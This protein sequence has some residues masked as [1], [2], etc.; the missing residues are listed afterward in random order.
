MLECGYV[1]Q[2]WRIDMLDWLFKPQCV[3]RRIFVT[4]A[5]ASVRLDL[6][7]RCRWTREDIESNLRRSNFKMPATTQTDKLSWALAAM[8]HFTF[9]RLVI[10]AVDPYIRPPRMLS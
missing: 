7:D 6:A 1:Y 9:T 10:L 8:T 3:Y 2:V 5:F 4:A